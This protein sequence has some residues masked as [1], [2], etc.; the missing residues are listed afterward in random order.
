MA[1]GNGGDHP[2]GPAGM[3]YRLGYADRATGAAP[4]TISML[5][6]DEFRALRT[7]DRMRKSRLPI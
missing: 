5:I 1:Q 4:R 6:V 7:L 2:G 3:R